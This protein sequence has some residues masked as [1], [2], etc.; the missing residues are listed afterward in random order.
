MKKIFLMLSATLFAMNCSA[1]K[2]EPQAS[3]TDISAV[4]R[5][6]TSIGGGGGFL[7]S[8]DKTKIMLVV[9]SRYKDQKLDLSHISG[10]QQIGEFASST[11]AKSV[12]LKTGAIVSEVYSIGHWERATKD[13]ND[14]N[15]IHVG[16]LAED[17]PEPKLGLGPVPGVN[18]LESIDWYTVEELKANNCCE[19]R[20]FGPYRV[21]LEH[22]VNNWLS[23]NGTKEVKYLKEK[24]FDYPDSVIFYQLL[25]KGENPQNLLAL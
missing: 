11:F 1:T 21:F 22:Y 3:A 20:Y 23:E 25:P 7:V 13:G 5:N 6:K 10:A 8:A 24:D 12:K 19:D 14:Y 18:Y 4:F 17:S 16:F 15:K 2:N 9:D